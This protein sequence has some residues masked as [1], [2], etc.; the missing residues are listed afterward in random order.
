MKKILALCL[1]ICLLCAITSNETFAKES[2]C[3][4]IPDNNI[5]SESEFHGKELATFELTVND[6]G[7]ASI[8]PYNQDLRPVTGPYWQGY[9]NVSAGK[10]M[11]VHVYIESYA[12]GCN[13]VSIH[14][15]EGSAVGADD[16][17]YRKA[18]WT[19]TGHHWAD[20]VKGTK[21][22]KYY[23]ML[24]GGFYGSGAIYTEP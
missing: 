7:E 10:N 3:T 21:A 1:S 12:F 14:V 20:L 15:K 18:T 24:W 8:V 22:G 17:K 9:V 5:L 6:D 19:G 23:V 2:K 4:E 13:S 11:K 16:A